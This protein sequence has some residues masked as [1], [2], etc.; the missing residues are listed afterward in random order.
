MVKRTNIVIIRVIAVIKE[1]THTFT[2]HL[3]ILIPSSGPK[4][5]KLKVAKNELI[6]QINP[7]I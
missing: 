7:M 1:M 4:G 3:I 2:F 6:R 5:S